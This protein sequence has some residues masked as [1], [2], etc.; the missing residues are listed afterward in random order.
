ML[1]YILKAVNS[2]SYIT[3][4]YEDFEYM[5]RKLIDKYELWGLKL[6]IKKT[7]YSKTCLKW[8]LY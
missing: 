2:V 5:T 8:T 1:V 7:K 6:N 4:V 3:L